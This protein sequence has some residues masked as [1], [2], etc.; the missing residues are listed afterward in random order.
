MIFSQLHPSY[1][2]IMSAKAFLEAPP[3][4]TES[5]SNFHSRRARV[6]VVTGYKFRDDE[7]LKAALRPGNAPLHGEP[8]YRCQQQLAIIGDALLK[9]IY[10]T[11]NF[12]D[13][14]E[15]SLNGPFDSISSNAALAFTAWNNGLAKA[16]DTTV[17][18]ANRAKYGESSIKSAKVAVA[19]MVEAVIGAVFLDSEQDLSVTKQAIEN[20]LAR[21]EQ[22]LA[23]G[24]VLDRAE[25]AKRTTHG[26]AA[27]EAAARHM[28]LRTDD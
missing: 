6:E 25:V 13:S 21:S 10:F 2:V 26:K 3:S 22:E 27:L 7:Y 16:M 17:P 19:T 18:R 24:K 8:I 11:H 5:S 4:D 15:G 12:P 9:L 20:V 14:S 23:S 28:K 1:S